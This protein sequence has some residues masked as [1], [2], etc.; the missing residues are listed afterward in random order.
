MVGRNP[1]LGFQYLYY[2]SHGTYKFG[3]TYSYKPQKQT[4]MELL[5]L[6]DQHGDLVLESGCHSPE[7]E[8]ARWFN[9]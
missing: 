2:G 8:L 7:Y 3:K 4:T 1:A 9:G 6:N 5:G